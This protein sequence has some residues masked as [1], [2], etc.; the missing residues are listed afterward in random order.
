MTIVKFLL[1]LLYVIACGVLVFTV[2]LQQGRGAGLGASLGGGGS[3]TLFGSRTSSFITR[4]TAGMAA[5]YMILAIVLAL[6]PPFAKETGSDKKDI[7][8]IEEVALEEVL[9]AAP[10][11]QPDAADSAPA[12]T[13]TGTTY[14][15]PTPAPAGP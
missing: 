15:E 4:L 8:N 1:V 12:E 10:A 2:L 7:L 9:D 11:D 5:V 14:P 13:E 3:Q 6:Y